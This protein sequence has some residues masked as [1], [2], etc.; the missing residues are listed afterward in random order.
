M[1]NW[2]IFTQSLNGAEP[3]NVITIR[4]SEDCHFGV[5]VR[6]GQRF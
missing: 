2:N 5:G 6:A 1:R 3:T 4:Q